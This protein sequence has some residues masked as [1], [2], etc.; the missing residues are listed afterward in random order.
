MQHPDQARVD[1]ERAK[2]VASAKIDSPKR[3]PLQGTDLEQAL[4]TLQ[5]AAGEETQ[6]QKK[7]VEPEPEVEIAPEPELEKESDKSDSEG[8]YNY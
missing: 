2:A 5:E 8:K 6:E 4:E 1:A 7:A 3:Q